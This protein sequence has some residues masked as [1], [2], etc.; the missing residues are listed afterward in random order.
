MVNPGLSFRW[1]HQQLV[2]GSPESPGLQGSA[3]E[4]QQL[5]LDLTNRVIVE[6]RFPNPP[7]PSIASVDC[8]LTNQQC[9]SQL[10]QSLAYDQVE[11]FGMNLIS[12]WR[13]YLPGRTEPG[14][15]GMKSFPS[16]RD[17]HRI[18]RHMWW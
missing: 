13:R 15:Y 5:H 1:L 18:R 17:P 6:V 7:A 12:P 11:I 8:T 2:A 4:S 14:T 10:D 3:A 16:L 9:H